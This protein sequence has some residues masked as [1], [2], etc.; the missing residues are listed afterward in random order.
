[1]PNPQPCYQT[2]AGDRLGVSFPGRW[3]IPYVFNPDTQQVYTFSFNTSNPPKV[4]D[5]FEIDQL[6]FPYK[7]SVAAWI[8]NSRLIHMIIV[9]IIKIAIDTFFTQGRHTLDTSRFKKLTLE[10]EIHYGLAKSLSLI[11]TRYIINIPR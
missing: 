9:V 1:M 4:N 2:L 5:V 6:I 8:L 11:K 10:E 7:F 3:P